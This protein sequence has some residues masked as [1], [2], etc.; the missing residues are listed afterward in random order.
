MAIFQAR[1]PAVFDGYDSVGHNVVQDGPRQFLLLDRHG[2]SGFQ[3]R[4]RTVGE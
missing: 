2:D 4:Y 1:I 3:P